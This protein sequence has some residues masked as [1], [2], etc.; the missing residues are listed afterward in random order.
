MGGGVV[1]YPYGCLARARDSLDQ[2][3]TIGFSTMLREKIASIYISIEDAL[4]DL[5]LLQILHF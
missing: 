3:N 2:D 4:I 5:N 1:R